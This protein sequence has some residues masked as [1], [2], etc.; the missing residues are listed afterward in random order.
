MA[1]KKNNQDTRRDCDGCRRANV[2]ASTPPQVSRP[3]LG[4]PGDSWSTVMKDLLRE[5]P[6]T[7]LATL[8]AVLVGLLHAVVYIVAVFA[9][10]GG[11]APPLASPI[12]QIV[13]VV[14]D[15][16]AG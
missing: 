8:G 11:A 10:C 5:S 14:I 16:L 4:E 7:A 12:R 13:Q 15:R 1:A 9:G 6:K 2:Q 3:R